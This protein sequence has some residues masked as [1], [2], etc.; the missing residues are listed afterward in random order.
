MSSKSSSNNIICRES[1]AAFIVSL[2]Q[3][4]E[5]I[6]QSNEFVDVTY[7]NEHSINVRDALRHENE[8]VIISDCENLNSVIAT[9]DH[10]PEINDRMD[11]ESEGHNNEQ[12]IS[13]CDE[14]YSEA[15]DSDK[16][17]NYYPPENNDSDNESNQSLMEMDAEQ[18][19]AISNESKYFFA[20]LACNELFYI[21]CHIEAESGSLLP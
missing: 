8:Q 15:D 3:T 5:A 17:A 13:E 6:R 10:T 12:D 2:S 19:E 14:T 7:L 20:T 18:V 21:L 1:R 9:N 16:D 4:A 11:Y